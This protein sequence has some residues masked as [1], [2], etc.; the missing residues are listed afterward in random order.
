MAMMTIVSHQN[1]DG[2]RDS[3]RSLAVAVAVATGGTT[4]AVAPA[5]S[6]WGGSGSSRSDTRCSYRIGA[7]HAQ[8]CCVA[9]WHALGDEAPAPRA[10]LAIGGAY[11]DSRRFRG[12]AAVDPHH[13]RG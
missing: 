3:G 10:L 7:P 8:A 4:P 13:R 11:V 1:S 2:R 6:G 5:R 12:G 9:V